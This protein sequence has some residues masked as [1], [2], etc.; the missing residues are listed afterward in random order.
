MYNLISS[1]FSLIEILYDKNKL[2]RP[3]ITL[4]NKDL[5]LKLESFSYHKSNLSEKDRKIIKDI[6]SIT[7]GNGFSFEKDK[8]DFYFNKDDNTQ[9]KSINTATG[10]K[11][12]GII[13]LLIQANVLSERSLLI[14]RLVL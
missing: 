12:F 13:Q 3:K 7:N 6:L 11:S 8:K 10:L 5:L 14:I 4:H 2:E 9:F 1:A